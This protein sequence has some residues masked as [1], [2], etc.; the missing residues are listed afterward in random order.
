MT[1]LQA[2]L[3]VALFLTAFTVL[4]YLGRGYWAWVVTV[5]IALGGWAVMEI[6]SPRAFAAALGASLVA[7]L[8]FGVPAMR[9]CV[10]TFWL[11]RPVGAMLPRM[12]DTERIALEAGT[13]SEE[14]TSELQSRSDLV[15]RLL[16]EK[17]KKH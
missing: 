10:V 6:E 9:R 16:L 3:L 11:M 2:G 8:V 13:R 12:G 4:L 1:A 5:A 14:H 7:T 15:C 17:K